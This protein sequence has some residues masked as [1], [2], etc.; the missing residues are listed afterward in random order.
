M[1]TKKDKR[2]RSEPVHLTEKFTRAIDYARQ[3]HVETRKKTLV[4]YMA[5]LMGVAA[6]VIAENGYVDFPENHGWKSWVQMSFGS[7]DLPTF[8]SRDLEPHLCNQRRRS[9]SVGPD[10]NRAACQRPVDVAIPSRVG[11]RETEPNLGSSQ[12]STKVTFSETVLFS[13]MNLA[14]FLLLAVRPN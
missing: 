5:H 8:R 11:N 9:P 3:I 6:L 4:P 7:V 13:R 1:T 12:P 14:I 10:L 2:S